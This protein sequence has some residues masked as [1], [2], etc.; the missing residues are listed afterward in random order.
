MIYRRLLFHI[1]GVQAPSGG[2]GADCPP[3]HELCRWGSSRNNLVTLSSSV[4]SLRRTR[5]PYWHMVSSWVYRPGGRSCKDSIG[6]GTRLKGDLPSGRFVA[7]RD[8]P[9]AARHPGLEGFPDLSVPRE[10][11][12]G[13][14][15]L[16][17]GLGRGPRVPRTR[18]SRRV[19]RDRQ[20]AELHDAG[21]GMVVPRTGATATMNPVLQQFLTDHPGATSI[22]A[23]CACTISMRVR[24]SRW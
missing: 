2:V 15:P 21:V 20:R 16:T 23:A 13:L 1:Q 24:A 18:R 9:E 17:A 8:D 22:A 5:R 12:N 11:G 7:P 3:V 6:P 14:T 19:P 4:S 10:H